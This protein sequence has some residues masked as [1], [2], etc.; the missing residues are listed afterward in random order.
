MLDIHRDSA[1]GRDLATIAGWADSS[2]ARRAAEA[3]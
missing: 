1:F 3:S 2:G